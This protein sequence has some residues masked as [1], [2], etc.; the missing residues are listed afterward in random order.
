MEAVGRIFWGTSCNHFNSS[1]NYRVRNV[2]S[3]L[4]RIPIFVR[5]AHGAISNMAEKVTCLPSFTVW[6]FVHMWRRKLKNK[7]RGNERMK[8]C[9]VWG[10]SASNWISLRREFS[11]SIQVENPATGRCEKNECWSE[12]R[13]EEKGVENRVICLEQDIY[14]VASLS[15]PEEASRR[16]HNICKPSSKQSL[17][18]KRFGSHTVDSDTA[19]TSRSWDTTTNIKWSA[20]IMRSRL[21]QATINNLRG[22]IWESDC[23]KELT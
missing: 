9:C 22:N 14:W 8:F 20:E 2:G 12:T 15:V 11:Y 4:I 18:S 5:K 6:S 19:S 1:R 17:P 13:L 7:N 3:Q 21:G 16:A 23:M 10:G